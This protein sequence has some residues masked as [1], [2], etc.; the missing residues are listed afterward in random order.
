MINI[1]AEH[2]L[3]KLVRQID[4]KDTPLFEEF[5]KVIELQTSLHVLI[6]SIQSIIGKLDTIIDTRYKSKTN[7]PL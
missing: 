2:T 4:P 1:M 5:K 6:N 7:K 3:E